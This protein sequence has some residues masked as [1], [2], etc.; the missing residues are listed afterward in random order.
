[1]T[2]LYPD[3]LGQEFAHRLEHR[4]GVSPGLASAGI[5]HDMVQLLATSWA[6]SP[7]PDDYRQTTGVLR[8]IVHRGVNGA[9]SFDSP[10]QTNRL[11]PDDAADPS[12]SQAHLVL[13]IQAGRHR[14]I[15]PTPYKAS[16]YLR[17][18]VMPQPARP[19]PPDPV[20]FPARL[21]QPGPQ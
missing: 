21:P 14:V 16:S 9:Y 19:S 20:R 1:V 17:P 13:Q 6:M 4:F 12:V 18:G 3:S 7:S 2:G 15:A 8:R 11:Y 10:S 5:H